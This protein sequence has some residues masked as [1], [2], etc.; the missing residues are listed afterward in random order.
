MVQSC[1]PATNKPVASAAPAPPPAPTGIWPFNAFEEP[2]TAGQQPPVGQPVGAQQP[3]PGP[4]IP[5]YGNVAAGFAMMTT[6]M[7]PAAAPESKS[8][9]AFLAGNP[10]KPVP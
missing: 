6:A 1:I 8:N 9:D 4:T 7:T 2:P 5:F 3:A 10:Y